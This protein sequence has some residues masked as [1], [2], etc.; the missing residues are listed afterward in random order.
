MAMA[1]AGQMVTHF[2]HPVHRPAS[3]TAIPS[4]MVIAFSGQAATHCSHPMQFSR[5]MTAMRTFGF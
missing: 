4:T 3:T 5:V 2:S 1:E